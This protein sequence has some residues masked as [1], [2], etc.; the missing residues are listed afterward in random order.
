DH[1]LH[2]MGQGLSDISGYSSLF[3]M[4]AGE[5]GA[6]GVD[7]LPV[8]S[9]TA[10]K[11]PR[12]KPKLGAS[13]W[14]WRTPPLWGL[15]DSAPYLHDGRADTISAAIHGHEGEGY[16]SA[17]KFEHLSRAERQQVEFFLLSLG[18]PDARRE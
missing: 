2:D 12:K 16:D 1:L 14:E 18:V 6:D 10:P 11:Q 3:S 9:N 7:P 13:A 17:Q 8:M 4:V 15:R 5:T